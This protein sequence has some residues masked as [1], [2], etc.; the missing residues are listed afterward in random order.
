MEKAS[1][2]TKHYLPRKETAILLINFA[3]VHRAS[4]GVISLLSN[5]TY[6]D[7][8][9]TQTVLSLKRV[10]DFLSDA[11]KEK[12]SWSPSQATLS[13]SVCLCAKSPV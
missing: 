8:K 5:A 13:L 7:G 2:I 9:N 12:L 3:L 1:C 6:C 10:K 11:R 4:I